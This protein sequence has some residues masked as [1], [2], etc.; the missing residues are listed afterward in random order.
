VIAACGVDVGDDFLHASASIGV[1]I[2]DE[3][4]E[5]AEQALLQADRA[6][7]AARHLGVAVGAPS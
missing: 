2:V 5:S 7:R 3:H 1:A 6:M 4:V